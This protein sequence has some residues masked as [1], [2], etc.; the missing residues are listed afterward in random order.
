METSQRQ[1]FGK[2]LAAER[3]KAG[4]SQEEL[5]DRA[6]LHRTEVSL[7]ERGLREPRLETLLKLA[8]GLGMQPATL[9]AEI[10]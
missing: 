5:G 6:G 10:S 8:R 1:H 7:I 3:K 9:I 2:T 4:L